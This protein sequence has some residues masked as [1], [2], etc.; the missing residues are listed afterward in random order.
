MNWLKYELTKVRVDWEPFES[1]R[2]SRRQ[3]KKCGQAKKL[4]QCLLRMLTK[5][6]NGEKRSQ[7]CQWRPND[8]QGYGTKV[9]WSILLFTPSKGY[10][11]K[12]GE[13]DLISYANMCSLIWTFSVRR[14]ILQYPFILLADNE[15]PDQPALM[16]RLIWACVVLKL[17]KGPFHALRIIRYKLQI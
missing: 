4:D 6:N 7:S 17:R 14:H 8:R 1:I 3:K 10:D 16:R 15:G 9:K 2:R 5:G 11:A 12:R 13:R